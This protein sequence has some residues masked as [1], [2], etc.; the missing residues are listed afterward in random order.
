MRLNI[1]SV[2]STLRGVRDLYDPYG[3]NGSL[4][5][6]PPSVSLPNEMQYTIRKLY[7][8]ERKRPQRSVRME[9]TEYA[10]NGSLQCGCIGQPSA[11]QYSFCCSKGFTNN[12]STGDYV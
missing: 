6:Q 8:M 3:S 12:M 11:M 2:N 5:L 10:F 1:R 7:F 4:D 9:R